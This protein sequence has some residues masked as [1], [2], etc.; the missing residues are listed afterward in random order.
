MIRIVICDD[1][2]VVR[3]GLEAILG[4]VPGFE[5]VGL[6]E[7]GADA[8]TKVAQHRPDLVLMDLKMPIMNGIR[9]TREI[10][11]RFPTVRVLVLTTYDDDPWVTDAIRSGAG[12]YL[13]KD[14]PR[15]KLIEAIRGTVAGRTHVDPSV[16]G[17]LFLH[18]ASQPETPSSVVF[19]DLS[20]RE[21]EVL[22]YLASGLGNV[23]IA[24]KLCLSEGTI[25]NYLTSIFDKLGVTDRTQA[26]IL[27]VRFGL[28]EPKA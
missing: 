6:A 18:I 3:E 19:A 17:K 7:H 14:A 23:Q 5:V 16:A 1:Q 21:R 27:A 12:G 24:K 2:E 8:L 13:L 25:R 28:G 4:R 10:R 26:A 15:E 11:E 22:G 9:A 20:E